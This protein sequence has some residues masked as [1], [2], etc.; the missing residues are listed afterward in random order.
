MGFEALEEAAFTLCLARACREDIGGCDSETVRV[1]LERE[2][3]S[4]RES[5]LPACPPS[6]SQG[7]L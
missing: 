4:T 1:E 3:G 6:E 7:S 5:V 2:H